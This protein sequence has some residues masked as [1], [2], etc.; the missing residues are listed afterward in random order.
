MCV[1]LLAFGNHGVRKMFEFEH[2]PRL[3]TF[4]PIQRAGRGKGGG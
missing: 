3:S 4:Q 1:C 2:H